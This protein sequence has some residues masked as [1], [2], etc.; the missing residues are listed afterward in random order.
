MLP[1]PYT[2]VTVTCSMSPMLLT[3]LWVSALTCSCAKGT[4]EDRGLTCNPGGGEGPY[5]PA[6]DG[7]WDL[8][9]GELPPMEDVTEGDCRRPTELL[10]QEET[11][12][13]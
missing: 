1:F 10:S 12:G 11:D 4:T 9:V 3:L 13:D 8:T 7:P 6:G 2:G 5:L